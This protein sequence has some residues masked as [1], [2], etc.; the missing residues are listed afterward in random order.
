MV[1][2]SELF[3]FNKGG[4]GTVGV[5]LFAGE[6]ERWERIDASLPLEEILG[7]INR[8]EDGVGISIVGDVGL[9]SHIADVIRKAGRPARLER[10]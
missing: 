4:I 7:A 2:G 8:L 10:A 6:N 3:S 9:T 5:V 1:R